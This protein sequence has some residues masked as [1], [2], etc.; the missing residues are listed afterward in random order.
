MWRKA[1]DSGVVVEVDSNLDGVA[2]RLIHRDRIAEW[3][4]SPAEAEALTEGLMIETVR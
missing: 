2:I 3:E 4:I 1:L